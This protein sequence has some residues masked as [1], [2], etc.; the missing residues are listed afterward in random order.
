MG[1]Q[2]VHQ[3]MIRRSM[4]LELFGHIRR[5]NNVLYSQYDNDLTKENVLH[6]Y[7]ANRLS[8]GQARWGSQSEES[9]SSVGSAFPE[10]TGT[11]RHDNIVSLTCGHLCHVR[12]TARRWRL[13]IITTTQLLTIFQSSIILWRHKRRRVKSSKHSSLY[14]NHMCPNYCR[15]VLL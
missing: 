12:S 6:T 15:T 14:E 2:W 13:T 4:K 10:S 5:H 8:A 1:R 3:Q 9:E 11:L 7:I